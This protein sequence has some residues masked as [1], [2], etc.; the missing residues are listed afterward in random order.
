LPAIDL[1]IAENGGAL[2]HLAMVALAEGKHVV[3]VNT[4]IDLPEKGY[5]KVDQQGSMVSIKEISE[6]RRYTDL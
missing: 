2:S 3:R 1:I 4:E 5:I 6:D